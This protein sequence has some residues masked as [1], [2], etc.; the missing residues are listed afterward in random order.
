MSEGPEHFQIR[1]NDIHIKN[2]I[3]NP[4]IF[5]VSIALFLSQADK[6]IVR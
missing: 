5:D 1:D 3:K 6:I 4:F 2:L